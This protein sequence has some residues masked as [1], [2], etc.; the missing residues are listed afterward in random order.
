MASK[1]DYYEILQVSKSASP[2]EIK[3]AYRKLAMRCHPDC[4]PGDKSAEEKFKEAAEAYEVLSD[5]TKRQRYDQFGHA[6]MNHSGFGNSGFGNVEDV[7]EHFGS[8]IENIFGM[9]DGGRKRSGGQ[10]PRKGSDLR[11][12]LKISFKES[13]LGAEKKIQIPK[14]SHCAPCEGSGAAK[15]T[16]PVTCP[17]CRGQGQVAV[18]QGFFTYASACPDCNGS[19]KKISTPCSDCKGSGFQMKTNSIN[20]KIPPGIDA[21]MRLRVGGE[22][23]SGSFGGPSGDLYVFID[24]ETSPHFKREEF[25]LVYILKISVAQ[26][27][28]GT[29]VFIDCFESEPRKIEVPAGTQ[30]GQRIVIHGAGV[31]KLEKYGRGKGDLIVEVQVEIPTKINKE[32]EEHLRAFAQKMGQSVKNNN[33]FFD[34][35]FG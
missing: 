6:G 19:G 34:K 4:N 11:Y 33:G 35:I 26:A 16:K 23:E 20:V 15:G 14:R 18:Q 31:H 25:D 9:G 8:I 24:V 5:S 17:T 2:D 21:G 32:A 29:E 10:K 7:F 27:I 1:R 12:D 28:L 22:G 13:I 3:K 30:P